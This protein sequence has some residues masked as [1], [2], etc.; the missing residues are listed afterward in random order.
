[1][2]Q[3]EEGKRRK[4]KKEIGRDRKRNLNYGEKEMKTIVSNH[5]AKKGDHKWR[6]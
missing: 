3:R 5:S 4:K 1:M 6:R 2:R